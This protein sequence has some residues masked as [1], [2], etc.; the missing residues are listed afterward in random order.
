MKRHKHLFEEITSLENLHLAYLK[1]RKGKQSKPAVESFT[2]HLESE[3]LKLQRE[4]SSETY[5]PGPYRQ[6]HVYESK[7]RLISAAPF[8]DRVVHHAIC[9]VIEPIFEATFIYDS[10][11]CRVGKGTHAAVRR[12]REF[13][14]RC[15]GVKPPN[16]TSYVLKCD[17]ARYFP[18][19]DH[20]ILLDL[21]RRKIADERVMR[22]LSVIISHSPPEEEEPAWFPGDDLLAPLRP[23]GLPIGNQ[24]SQFFANVYLNPFDHFVKETPRE[25]YYLRYVDDFIILGNDKKRLH[26]VKESMR[27]FLFGL[28]LRLHENKTQVF[29]AKEGTDFLGYRIFP[30]HARVR[31][32]NVHRFKRRLKRFQAAY[33]SGEITLKDVEN[34]IRSWLAHAAHADS[35]QLR[36]Q[37]MSHAIFKK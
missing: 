27:E 26:D 34:S 24:T 23:R 30:T 4:L 21:L 20:Q 10:Y 33:A 6:F 8:R 1:A 5:I 35:Y 14:K 7:K 15:S 28:R 32:S 37:L 16:N 11:A 25:K 17:I 9:N 19:I 3:L 2:F 22:L 31:K 13:L 18:S 36:R 29:P 12:F